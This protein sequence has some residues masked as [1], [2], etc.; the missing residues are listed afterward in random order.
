MTQLDEEKTTASDEQSLSP[1]VP[2]TREQGERILSE[3]KSIKQNIFLLILL[4]GFF[5]VRALLFHY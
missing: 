5:A 2:I 1:S 3:L 4:S